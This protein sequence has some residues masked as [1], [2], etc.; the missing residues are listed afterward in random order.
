MPTNDEI[1]DHLELSNVSHTW[2][3]NYL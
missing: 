3:V 2:I 1:V